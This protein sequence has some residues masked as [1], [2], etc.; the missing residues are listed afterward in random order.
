MFKKTLIIIFMILLILGGS[1]VG[2]FYFTGNKAVVSVFNGGVFPSGNSTGFTPPATNQGSAAQNEASSTQTNTADGRLH[3][4][5]SDPVAGSVV[6]QSASTTNIRYVD[7]ATG[8]VYDARPDVGSPV[9][10]SNTTIPKIS[11][12]LWNP[13][14]TSVYLRYLGNNEVIKTFYAKL[15]APAGT[16]T[17]ASPYGLEGSFLP[18]NI[19]SLSISNTGS[20]LF[21]L[22][23]SGNGVSGN[24]SNLDGTKKVQVF[25]SP[26]TH[27]QSLWLGDTSI[28]LTSNASAAIPGVA[29]TVSNLTAKTPTQQKLLANVYALTTLTN[30]VGDGVI[31]SES[32]GGIVSLKYLLLKNKLVKTLSLK[33][34]PEKCVWS[35]KDK[36]ILYCAIPLNMTVG[37]T[38]DSWYQGLTSFSDSFWKINTLTDETNLVYSAQ[39][40]LY[41]AVNLKL[42]PDEGYLIF[43]N[44]KD[45][46]LWSLKTI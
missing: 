36:N 3:L 33:T 42:S 24:S 38:P 21:Y 31:Y 45:G 32:I 8:H 30:P 26:L 5:T 23:S 2:Y 9:Q 35:K 22:G 28:L 7:R 1:L 44:K 10:I 4:I 14:G 40:G 18:D 25:T 34:L 17:S 20:K 15:K 39:S 19:T 11:E 41:D 13:D 27:W 16:S 12:A 37:E 43:T 29:L 6:L 46:S